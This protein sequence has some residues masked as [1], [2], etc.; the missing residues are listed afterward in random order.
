[1]EDNDHAGGARD[2][3][4][5]CGLLSRRPGDG[6]D[7]NHALSPCMEDQE[8]RADKK[9]KTMRTSPGWRAFRL[10]ID[11]SGRHGEKEDEA[12]AMHRHAADSMLR[13]LEKR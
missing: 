1:V 2:Q 9:K 12:V 10:A 11:R 8:W 13:P 5:R 7:F 6:T 4:R 3:E